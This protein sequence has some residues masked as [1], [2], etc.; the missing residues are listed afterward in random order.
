M[1]KEL[2]MQQINDFEEKMA[3]VM[4]LIGSVA[5]SLNS[6]IFYPPYAYQA[7]RAAEEHLNTAFSIIYNTVASEPIDL[8]EVIKL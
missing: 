8:Q 7:L 2:T 6:E 3:F 4:G 1:A 5:T